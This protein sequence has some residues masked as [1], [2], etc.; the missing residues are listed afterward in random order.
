[1]S[2]P[3][4]LR[5]LVHVDAVK[6]TGANPDEIASFCR[7]AE[8][9]G[10]VSVGSYVVKDAD[11]QVHVFPAEAFT[12]LFRPCIQP[13]R[14]YRLHVARDTVHYMVAHSFSD[15]VALW[16]K[17]YP[18]EIHEEMDLYLIGHTADDPIGPKNLL[19]ADIVSRAPGVNPVEYD[20]FTDEFVEG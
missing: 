10:G 8:P 5:R 1:M 7:G 2:A 15:A 3:F 19:V 4:A 16:S 18:E 9:R 20:V 13:R 14:L 11:Q 17:A 12:F 6:Y